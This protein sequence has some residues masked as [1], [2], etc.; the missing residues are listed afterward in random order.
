M[1]LVLAA[2]V[3]A[4]DWAMMLFE[5]KLTLPPAALFSIEPV[6]VIPV[7]EP[8]EVLL[9]ATERSEPPATIVIAPNETIVDAA[10]DVPLIVILLADIA[11]GN[12]TAVLA[13]DTL[14][15]VIAPVFAVR[16]P[17]EVPLTPGLVVELVLVEVAVN[18]ILPAV[19]VKA[20][21]R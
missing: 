17:A 10:V 1:P 4:P 14:L 16:V 2:K 20:E 5:T 12:D 21:V 11:P 18:E 9:A 15:I 8:P 7:F 6:C 19:E 13:L 3:M